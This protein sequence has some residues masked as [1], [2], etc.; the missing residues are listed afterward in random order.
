MITFDLTR[1]DLE[2]LVALGNRMKWCGGLLRN[3]LDNPACSNK[4]EVIDRLEDTV[5]V[6][7][8]IILEFD[9]RGV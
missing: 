7:E 4:K 2:R 3:E 1:M 8:Q 5:F 6:V 9:T